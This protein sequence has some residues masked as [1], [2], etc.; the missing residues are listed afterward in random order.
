M[1][2][3]LA[4]VCRD[5]EVVLT[6]IIEAGIKASPRPWTVEKDGSTCWGIS[7]TFEKRYI[8]ETDMGNYNPNLETASFI[9]LSVNH[10]LGMALELRAQLDTAWNGYSA[11]DATARDKAAGEKF[12]RR[13][14]RSVGVE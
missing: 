3:E 5:A 7:S 6:A 8:V 14:A 11:G 10:S 4:L 1:E 13:I 2:K 9:C 12:I